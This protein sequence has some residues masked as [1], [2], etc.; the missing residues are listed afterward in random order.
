M[1]HEERRM[2]VFLLGNDT[3]VFNTFDYEEDNHCTT[4]CA[5]LLEQAG[6]KLRVHN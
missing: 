4:T 1:A 6:L 5:M 3:D 2:S